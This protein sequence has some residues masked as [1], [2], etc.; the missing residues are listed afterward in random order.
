M[1]SRYR[2]DNH[3]IRVGDINRL[4][5][6]WSEVTGVSPEL[7]RNRLNR[8]WSPADAVYRKPKKYR[9]NQERY[10]EQYEDEDDGSE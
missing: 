4:L 9:D 2:K 6:E 3:F 5:T 8:G 7:I 10:D 1:G